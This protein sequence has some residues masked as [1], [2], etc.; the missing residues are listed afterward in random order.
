MRLPY[1]DDIVRD[2][3][4]VCVLRRCPR[5]IHVARR[6][7]H[8]ERPPWGIRHICKEKHIK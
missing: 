1:V 6:E 5:Q 7:S 2:G 8:Y 4:V 3:A